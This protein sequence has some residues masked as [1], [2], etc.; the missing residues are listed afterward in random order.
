MAN[1]LVFKLSGKRANIETGVRGESGT[2]I[3]TQGGGADSRESFGITVSSIKNSAT[4]LVYM[5]IG[6]TLINVFSNLYL[7]YGFIKKILF[8]LFY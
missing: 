7:Y 1:C 5:G 6:M 3:M 8:K 2:K 4:V